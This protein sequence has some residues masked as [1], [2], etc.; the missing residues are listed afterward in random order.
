NKEDKIEGIVTF[1]SGNKLKL[2]ARVDELPDWC[3]DGKL[4]VDL[5]FDD[6]SYDEMFSALKAAEERQQKNDAATLINI[7]TGA[8]SPTF[9][10]EQRLVQTPTLN[11]SQQEAVNTIVAANNLAIVHGP[12]GTG[13][14]TTLVHA[15]KLL[16]KS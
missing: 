10:Y 14:T 16:N 4:G 7:V 8:K 1:Q 2:S 15:I 6:N 9:Y 11:N 13:K 5:L 12:P 3:R